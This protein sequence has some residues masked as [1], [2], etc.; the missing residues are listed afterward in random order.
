MTTEEVKI[1]H[2]PARITP[3]GDIELMPAMHPVCPECG[4]LAEEWDLMAPGWAIN[5]QIINDE[6]ALCMLHQLECPECGHI[7]T[8]GPEVEEDNN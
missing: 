4:W 8:W 7:S 6:P 1:V 2:G 3:D 5:V